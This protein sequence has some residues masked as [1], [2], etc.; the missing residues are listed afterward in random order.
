[1]LRVGEFGDAHEMTLDSITYRVDLDVDEETR[2]FR[3]ARFE[4]NMSFQRAS[5]ILPLGY[6][7]GRHD[8]THSAIHGFEL[9]CGRLQ[10][11]RITLTILSTEY[12]RPRSARAHSRSKQLRNA[13]P[14]VRMYRRDGIRSDEKFLRSSESLYIART[15]IENQTRVIDLADAV[16]HMICER[17]RMIF[18]PQ[19]DAVPVF[20]DDLTGDIA[21]L[22]LERRP[23]PRIDLDRQHVQLEPSR[24]ARLLEGSNN[25]RTEAILDDALERLDDRRRLR[26]HQ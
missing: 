20:L 17:A 25:H 8:D 11:K 12:E 4:L 16:S 1:M 26:R 15:D 19:T 5:C 22:D 21:H 10:M 7:P 9:A 13:T 2:E 14:I 23:I 18:G 24:H 3:N 6:V